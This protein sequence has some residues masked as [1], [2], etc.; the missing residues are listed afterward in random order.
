MS[1]DVVR[2]RE[3]RTRIRYLALVSAALKLQHVLVDH[4]NTGGSR[5][6][7]EGLESA[8]GVD[9]KLAAQ[10]EMQYYS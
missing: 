6:V 7:A 9:R 2:E 4:P 1:A 8:I 10:L 5:R 3:L